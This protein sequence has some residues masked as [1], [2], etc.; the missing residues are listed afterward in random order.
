MAYSTW[1]RKLLLQGLPYQSPAVT[2]NLLFFLCGDTLDLVGSEAEKFEAVCNC[3]TNI[4]AVFSDP[5]GEQQNVHAAEQSNV[6]TDCL[7]H[8]NHKHIQRKHGLWI[9][10]AGALF[11]RL[12]IAFA[13]GESE[14][15]ALM[16]DEVFHRVG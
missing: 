11:K 4:I 13:T 8:G 16:I 1:H 3:G 14:E 9:F 2:R 5:A 12:H 15:A 10:G 7:A 6:C